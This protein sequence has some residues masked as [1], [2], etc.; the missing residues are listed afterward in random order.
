MKITTKIDTTKDGLEY[1]NMYSKAKTPL[2]RMLSD[3]FHFPIE[4]EDGHFESVEGYW[5]WLSLPINE[6]TEIMRRLYGFQ[7]KNKGREL[8]KKYGEENLRFD[9]RFEEKILAAIRYKVER[10]KKLIKPEYKNLPIIHYYTFDG[11]VFDVTEDF[12]WLV[13]GITDIVRTV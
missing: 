11:K 7:A 5:Y 2:G 12:P 13:A 3:F 8:R 4:T 10:N 1:I 6:E 9:E